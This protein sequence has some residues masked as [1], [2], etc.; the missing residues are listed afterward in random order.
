MIPVSS[1]LR[2]VLCGALLSSGLL[3][4]NQPPRI[5][6]PA[7]SPAA[8]FKQKVGFT[9]IEVS[10]ARPSARGRQIFGGLVPYG[11]VWRTGA[12]TATKVT[13][14]T[15]VKIGG[16]SLAA[17]SY[18]LYSVPG[19]SEWTVIFNKVTGEWGAYAYKREND[20]L[21]V[22]AKAAKLSQP[23]ETFTIEINDITTE[24][25]TLNLVWE[26]TRVPVTIQVDA[27]NQVVAQIDALVASGA[28]LTPAEAYTAAMFYYDHGLDLNKAK[29]WVLEATAGD[30]PAFFRLHGKAKIL[31]KLG[32]KAGAI[33]AAK[34]S[35]AAAEGAAK[36][37][38]TRLNE[39]LIASLK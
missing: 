1:L 23:V 38:Y 3:A 5:T 35:I 17:G 15:A 14:G 20:A 34:A 19:K 39:A 8:S 31:A 32:D 11:E 33:A 37:E 25:A 22:T 36:A 29:A 30:K 13:F 7:P 2:F 21:R 26:K 6:A 18:A 27:I 9:D 12:N 28:K 16:Q 10:Y 4:Q 24:S